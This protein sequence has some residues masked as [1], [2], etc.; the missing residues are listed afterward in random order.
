ML[1]RYLALDIKTNKYGMH[2]QAANYNT[3]LLSIVSLSL[4][5][6]LPGELYRLSWANMPF[7]LL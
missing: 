2:S 1:C 7:T 5:G 6:I 4:R 3:N